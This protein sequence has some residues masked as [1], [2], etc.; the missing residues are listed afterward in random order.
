MKIALITLNYNG[1]ESTIKLLES[2]QNQTDPDF[3]LIVADNGSTDIQKLRDY[4]ENKPIHIIENGAN[5]GFGGGC[6]IAIKRALKNGASWLVLLNNDTWVESDFISHLKAILERTNGLV[7]LPIDEGDGEIA[8]GGRL[9][10]LSPT[11]SH[12]HSFLNHKQ[13]ARKNGKNVCYAIGGGM[14]IDSSAVEKIGYFDENYFLYFEDADLSMRAHEAGVPIAF[15]TKPIIHHTVSTTTRKLGAPLLLRYHYRNALYFNFKNAPLFYKIGAIFWSVI[16]F[17]KQLVKLLSNIHPAESRAILAGIIDFY[18]ERMGPVRSSLA[19]V[20]RTRAKGASETSYG[21]GRISKK[22]KVGI[23]C[24]QIEGEIWGVGKIITKLLENIASRPELE[25]DFEFHLY[26]KSK[27]PKL[28]FLDNSIFHK[29]VIEQPFRHKS[30]VFY[31]YVLLPIQLWFERLDVMFFPNYMLPIIFFGNSVV[32]L[33]EDIYYEMRSKQQRFHHRLAY[34][35]FATWATWRANKIMAI[36]QT[37]KKE[38]VRLFNIEPARIVVNLLAVD[39]AK[40]DSFSNIGNCPPA[41]ALAKEGKLKNEN[42]LLFVGQ[43]FPRR[44]L[45]ESLLAFEKIASE[46]QDLKFIIVGPDKYNPPRIRQLQQD[47]NSRLGGERIIWHERVSQEELSQLYAHTL[48]TIYISSREAFGLPPL[49]GLAQGSVPIIAENALGHELFEECAVFIANPDSV[50][51]IA[52][53]LREA[54]TNST[55]REK[56]KAH[57]PEIVD[58]YT[59]RAHTDRFLEIIKSMTRH[60]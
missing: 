28:L 26:F 53:A 17:V 50:D 39:S 34:R 24:E 13:N 59:W 22:I 57:A 52:S 15:P 58:R 5:L 38:L 31:Y 43:S 42:Y 2:L 27:I 41:E 36:S 3:S 10:W 23:E 33:T 40:I 8:M 35:V 30:F 37:S 47:I 49:E 54:M 45:A 4:C 56:I 48:A 12:N 11:L 60:A 16:I 44:H 9:E 14:A 32:M 46:F 21:M 18:Q 1:A 51:D 6:N 7:G 20:R 29:K 25:K 19:E 55:L